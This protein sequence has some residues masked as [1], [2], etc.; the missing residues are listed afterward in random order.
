MPRDHAEH[1][2]RTLAAFQRVLDSDDNLEPIEVT[3][4][5]LLLALSTAHHHSRMPPDMAVKE[6]L[7]DL[8]AIYLQNN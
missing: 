6:L 5:A 3:S 4:A 7:E 8:Y 2:T 1:I